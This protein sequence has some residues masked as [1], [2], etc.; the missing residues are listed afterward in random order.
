MAVTGRSTWNT[1]PRVPLEL[2]DDTAARGVVK[3]NWVT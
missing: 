2:L 1:T 3:T